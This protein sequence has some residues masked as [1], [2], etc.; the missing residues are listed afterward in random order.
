MVK[1]GKRDDASLLKKMRKFVT[2]FMK[3]HGEESLI[4]AREE[5]PVLKP[6]RG[7]RYRFQA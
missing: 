5:A 2:K 3:E 4:E 7:M 1:Y 6:K